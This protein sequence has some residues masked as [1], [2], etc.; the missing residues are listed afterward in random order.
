MSVLKRKKSKKYNSS[1][2]LGI[3]FIH[4]ESNG[5]LMHT[6]IEYDIEKHRDDFVLVTWGNVVNPTMYRV[7]DV[8]SYLKEGVWIKV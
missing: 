7:K 1:H 6:I 3:K 4:P 5:D 8:E 2:L